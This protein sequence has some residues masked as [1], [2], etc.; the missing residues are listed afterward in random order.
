[1]AKV[2]VS[3]TIIDL[4]SERQAVVDWLVAAQHQIVH[5]YWPDS[6]TAR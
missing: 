4:K 1:M 6:D 3:S 2:Y 5:S